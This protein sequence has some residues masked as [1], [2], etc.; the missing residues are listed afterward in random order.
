MPWLPLHKQ[1]QYRERY[2]ALKPSWQPA[3]EVYESLVA[4]YLGPEAK[5]LDV[6]CGRGGVLE[7]LHPKAALSAGID[8]DIPSLREHRAPA[9]KRVAAKA[10]DIPFANESFDLVICSWVLEHLR[11]PEAAFREIGR[12][13]KPGGH[14]VFLT[15]NALHPIPLLNRLS[16][17]RLQRVLVPGFYGRAEEDTFSV[18]YRANA[19]RDIERF[20]RKAGMER[21]SLHYIEDPTY[22]AINDFF[23]RLGILMERF[24]PSRCKVHLVGDY[25]KSHPGNR[26]G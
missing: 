11:E 12:V 8:V 2:K 22:I 18:V 3:T 14:F 19:E 5:V 4:G 25:I 21:V 6:G 16:P 10:E 17:G 20:A 1:E 15:P 9:V 24:I 26:P 13:L 7:R 23:F